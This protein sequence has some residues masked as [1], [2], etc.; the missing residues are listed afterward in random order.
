[1]MGPDLGGPTLG[2]S[3]PRPP[4][5]GQGGA[6]ALLA[7]IEAAPVPT[8]LTDP[9]RPDNPIVLAN[10]AFARLTGYDRAEVVGR[11]C[12]FLQG[13]DTDPGAVDAIRRAVLAR[14]EVA[15]ELLNYRKDG[16][17]FWN[18][19]SIAPVFDAAGGLVH[20]VASQQ[21]VSRRRDAEDAPLRAADG[22]G[23]G[24]RMAADGRQAG[25]RPVGDVAHDLVNMLQVVAGHMDAVK[26]H[27]AVTADP[28]LARRI[29]AVAD[30][31]DRATALIRELRGGAPRSGGRCRRGAAAPGGGFARSAPGAGRARILVVDDRAEVAELARTMLEGEGHAVEVAGDGRD[32]LERLRGGFDLLFSDVVMPGSLD[33]VALA[34]EARLRHPGL[35]VLLTTGQTGP[36]A[37]AAI[38]SAAGAETIAKPYRRAELARTIRRIL[39][40]PEGG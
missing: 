34:R 39:D 15:V 1:M 8:V 20:F 16:T 14:G 2:G 19:L 33:G 28:R 35:K 40:G 25:A 24:G 26:G 31:A 30:A 29:R 9:N 17:P 3:A 27:A 18:A 10:A 11:N 23:R 21:D 37:A 13:P 32:A 4:R 5:A 6:D 38:A 22:E 7:A 12:R 36:E